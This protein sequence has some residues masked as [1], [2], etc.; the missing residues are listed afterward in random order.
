M[1]FRLSCWQAGHCL[2]NLAG[3]RTMPYMR[4]M[5]CSRIPRAIWPAQRF[6]GQQMRSMAVACSSHVMVVESPAKAK[7]IQK[8]V[9]SDFTVLASYGHIRDLRPK[10]GS[11][12]PDDWTNV[13]WE[14][15]GKGASTLRGIGSHVKESDKLVLA[16]DPDREGEAISWHILQEL[17]D[18]GL[19]ADGLKIERVTFTEVTKKAVLKAMKNPRQISSALIDAYLA[20]R[21]LDYLVGFTLSPLLWRK[22]PGAKSAGRVQSVALRIV[23]ERDTEIR[24]FIPTEYWSVEAKLATA[25]GAFDALLVKIGGKRLQKMDLKNESEAQAAVEKIQN[26]SLEVAKVDSKETKRRPRPPFMT[27]TLQQEALNKLGFSPFRTDKLAQSLYEGANSNGDGLITY[28]RTDSISMSFEAIENIRRT[29]KD[30]F[31]PRYVPKSPRIF[32]SKAKNAQEAHEAIRPTNPRL[33]PQKLKSM[34]RDEVKLYELIWNRS[35]ACQMSDARIIQVSVDIEGSHREVLLRSTDS[36]ISFEGYLAAYRPSNEEDKASW[37]S[38]HGN[39]LA[40]LAEN[41]MVSKK[42]VTP[43]Q[44]FTSPPPRYTE[45]TLVKALEENGIGR[46]STYSSTLKV[47]KDRKYIE[48]KGRTVAAS[49]RGQVLTAFL[50]KYFHHYLDYD[51]TSQMEGELDS[52]AGGEE[53]WTQV[54]EAFWHPFKSKVT[55]VMDN[56]SVT[57]VVDELDNI[58]CVGLFPPK[59]DGSDPRQCPMCKDGQLRFKPSK[60]SGGFI[61]CSNY[62]EKGCAYAA[63]LNLFGDGVVPE[64]H[65]GEAPILGTDP[66]TGGDV[67]LRYGRFGPYIH[68][69]P[70]K[71]SP[72]MP[73]T[74]SLPKRYPPDTVDLNLAVKLLTPLREVG[75]HPDEGGMVEIRKGRF[76]P[77]VK[78]G[79]TSVLLKKGVKPENVSLEMALKLLRAKERETK[80]GKGKSKGKAKKVPG[81]ERKTKSPPSAYICFIKSDRWN[82][83]K[84][85]HPGIKPS[86]MMKIMGTE[87][88]NLSEEEKRPFVE[89]A[90]EGKERL[91]S[92]VKAEKPKTKDSVEGAK[93]KVGPF[94]VFCAVHRAPVKA[95]NPDMKFGDIAKRLGQMWRDLD[96]S[97]RAVYRRIGEGEVGLEALDES[98]PTR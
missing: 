29:V 11:I 42:S 77:Y 23:C 18:R 67:S 68:C 91:G 1:G 36:R 14:M 98:V 82:Q 94:I 22:L 33:T 61:G 45:A 15:N 8:Y 52:I 87:W 6:V 63:P 75:F 17:K 76:S 83:V 70:S 5:R 80:K 16:T 20:R 64:S 27:S 25:R 3:K 28:M 71:E 96:D 19:L 49:T 26:A 79:R 41:E 95:D 72:Y 24:E 48:N 66:R 2:P 44:H 7:K 46:P 10:G 39:V 34:P 93:K 85:E 97:E 50:V 35:M 21:A 89:M 31:G 86:E 58:L 54:L 40:L 90:K 74:V 59:E 53:E 56:V 81:V 88:R 12:R 62:Q 9:G 32:S 92:E 38:G 55:E 51:F 57:E 65:G 60:V 47:L 30:T 13:T 84:E 73:S 43:S 4:M 69:E 78:H 37:M